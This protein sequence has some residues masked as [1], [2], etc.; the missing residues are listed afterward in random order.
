MESL[1]VPIRFKY[2]CSEIEIIFAAR[3]FVK[4]LI[5]PGHSV[6]FVAFFYDRLNEFSKRKAKL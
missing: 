4:G 2:C 3:L 5:F 1:H 6:D